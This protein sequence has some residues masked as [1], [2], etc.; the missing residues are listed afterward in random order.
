MENT[1]S[2]SLSSWFHVSRPQLTDADSML[3]RIW[4]ANASKFTHNNPTTSETGRGSRPPALSKRCDP[5][6]G[7]GN[8]ANA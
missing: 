6:S 2:G 8:G 3:I 4:S 5:A 1:Q 7:P